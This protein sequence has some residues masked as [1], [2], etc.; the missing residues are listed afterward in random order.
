MLDEPTIAKLRLAE[1]VAALMGGIGVC[2]VLSGSVGLKLCLS[3][4]S[5]GQIDDE[6]AALPTDD[7][8]LFVPGSL[9]VGDG[10]DT[11]RSVMIDGGFRHDLTPDALPHDFIDNETGV[12]I[13]F[14]DEDWPE[15]G[16]GRESF[17]TAP[18]GDQQVLVVP[19]E[20]YL[21]LYERLITEPARIA[22][23]KR[24]AEKLALIRHAFE[25]AGIDTE[26]DDLNG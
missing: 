22:A 21:R 11:L 19:A 10:W 15:M 17:A 12:V 7:I 3:L 4:L 23:G 5:D 14:S 20:L 6:L 16:I 8:D 9:L 13:S 18:L 25:A 24:D 1:R 2:P 26:V